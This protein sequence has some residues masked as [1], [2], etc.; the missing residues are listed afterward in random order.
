MDCVCVCVCSEG[1]LGSSVCCELVGFLDNSRACFLHLD[2]TC[3]VVCTPGGIDLS[4]PV[5][6][7]E[8]EIRLRTRRGLKSSL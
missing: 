1:A 4:C 3:L 5:V 8:R 7:D 2:N 6:E